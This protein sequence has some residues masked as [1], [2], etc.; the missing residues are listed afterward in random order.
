MYH[1]VIGKRLVACLNHRDG[2][3]F[4][5]RQFF[6]Q[7]Y[8]PLF[9]G[10]ARLMQNINNSPFD[11]AITKQK[12]P[13]T[14]ELQQ[15]CL[16]LVH[17]K[18]QDLEPDASFFLGGPASGSIETTS[19]QVTSMRIPVKPDDVYASWIGAALGLTVQ[20]GMA[21]LVDDDAVLLTTYDGWME[22]RRYLDQTPAVKPLQINTWNGQW[23]THR[24]GRER[25]MMQNIIVNKDG[26]ALETQGWVQL[27][28][29]LSYHFREGPLRPLLAYV[30]SLGQSNK[31]IGFVRLNLLQVNRL[32]DLYRQL[33]TIPAGMQ[34]A[35]F[36]SLYQT[37]M[38]FYSACER[39]EVGLYALRPKD[40]FNAQRSVPKAP[41]STDTDKQL[42]F[43]TYQIWIIAMLN[44]K[45]LLQRAQD[46]AEA[47]EHFRQQGERGKVVNKQLVE[48]LLQK[49]GRRDFI[50]GLTEL[51]YKDPGHCEIYEQA[52]ADILSLPVDNVALFITLLRF[53]YAAVTAK[54][55]NSK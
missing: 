53:K 4:T 40:A 26:S 33:F 27:L 35:A 17:G 31:T 13:F 23:V 22:Y 24:M 52:A 10:S 36:E 49:K 5:V 50:E 46:L 43:Q 25:N 21:L 20:G 48:D 55:E 54:K 41:T 1:S 18:V 29:S 39:T 12:K 8:I 32:V 2:T 38:S 47:L 11:Q 44:N 16:R 51:L 45:E 15:E 6:D 14:I 3:D 42:A 19:G 37:E 30:Y 7:V 28:F 34:P 9:F